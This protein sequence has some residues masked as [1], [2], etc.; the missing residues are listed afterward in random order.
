MKTTQ[1]FHFTALFIAVSAAL[2]FWTPDARAEFLGKFQDWEAH[3]L[4][5]GGTK[6]C[7]AATVPRKSEGKYTRRGDVFLLVS[8]RPGDKMIGYVSIEAGYPY[9]SKSKI[10]ARIGGA[11]FP[12][13]PGGELAFAHEDRPL[14][15]AMIRGQEMVVTG[16]S[17]R[18]TLTTDTF[19]LSGFT[20][21]YK[22]A[23]KECGVNP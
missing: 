6:V 10:T 19:S 21:A 7:Y 20:A 9:G 15:E 17:S 8:H 12:M 13:Y 16:T 11:S 22:T 3:T 14:V 2:F 23:S 18:G 4:K 5:D 1:L